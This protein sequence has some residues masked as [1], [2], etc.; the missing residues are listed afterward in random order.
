MGAKTRQEW[1]VC[2]CRFYFIVSKMSI[3]TLLKINL[4]IKCFKNLATL[5]SPVPAP[6]FCRLA[7]SGVDFWAERTLGG[8][9]SAAAWG[10]WELL[11]KT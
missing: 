5:S 4:A 8:H 1:A 9:V 2:E 11:T 7:L 3:Y 6:S 10:L